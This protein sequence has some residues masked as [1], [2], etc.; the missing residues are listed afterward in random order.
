MGS[1]KD[2]V[3]EMF[4]HKGPLSEQDTRK[5]VSGLAE[6]LLPEF[7]RSTLPEI[8][9]LMNPR[10]WKPLYEEM[11]EPLCPGREFQTLR[12]QACFGHG[13]TEESFWALARDGTW[14][15]GVLNYATPGEEPGSPE[16]SD[17]DSDCGKRVK[18]F[19]LL[20]S[21]VGEVISVAGSPW[22][23]ALKLV[24]IAD[25]LRARAK[26]RYEQIDATATKIHELETLINSLV[27]ARGCE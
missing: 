25:E 5:L 6:L 15:Y 2:A 14:L 4:S 24:E 21:N 22:K 18:S 11:P 23:V 3:L 12:T 10:T 17:V 26:T 20:K 7:K 13:R 19:T 9:K 27:A 8:G 1:P 16:S